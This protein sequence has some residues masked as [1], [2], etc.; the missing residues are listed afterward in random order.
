MYCKVW[1]VSQRKW[2]S[3]AAGQAELVRHKDKQT[4][5]YH[6]TTPSFTAPNLGWSSGDWSPGHWPNFGAVKVKSSETNEKWICLFVFFFFF[7]FGQCFGKRRRTGAKWSVQF[8]AIRVFLCYN[9]TILSHCSS[10]HSGHRVC[11]EPLAKGC[12]VC[13]LQCHIF[14]QDISN[15]SLHVQMRFDTSWLPTRWQIK[16]SWG[17][18][19]MPSSPP[20]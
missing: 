4:S 12:I 13:V 19:R 1:C 7:T 20:D 14:M 16:T 15:A 9:E 10:F 17:P 5:L 2:C 18:K 6:V 3:I 8:S 11:H